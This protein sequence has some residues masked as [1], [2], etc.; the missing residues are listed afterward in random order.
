MKLKLTHVSK[1]GPWSPA[2]MVLT[3]L[4]N[5]HARP[6]FPPILELL[7][8]FEYHFWNITSISDKYRRCKP[9]TIPVK[10]ERDSTSLI[11][12][13]P[14]E[15]SLSDRHG[16]VNECSLGNSH[17]WSPGSSELGKRLNW[18]GDYV[19]DSMMT[20]SNGNIFRI[21]GSLCGEFTGHRWIPRT[22]ASD[23]QHWCFLWSAPE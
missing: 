23:A 22:K 6:R 2:A 11:E 13:I 21:T 16:D 10:Y 4:S 15:M 18:F 20:S 9:A 19:E 14:P 7:K 3:M 17:H 8:T 5:R 1:T 12:N